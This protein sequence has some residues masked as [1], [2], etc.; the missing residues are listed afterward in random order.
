MRHLKTILTLLILTTGTVFSQEYKLTDFVETKLPKVSSDEWFELNHSRNEFK[1]FI[2]NGAIKIDKA[3]EEKDAILE[4]ETGRLVG[5]DHGEWGGKIEFIPKGTT[6]K[7]LI[8]EGNVK[9]IFRFKSEI[10]FI[11][12]LAH[13]ST[14]KG[15][16]YRLD[17]KVD[18]FVPIKVIEFEDAPEA[19][20]IF[21]D[22]I[23]IAAH[24][25]FFL[26]NDLD[27]KMIFEK[28][29]WSGLYPNSVAAI[30]NQNIYIGHRG[31]FTKLDILNK[32]IR[33][34]KFRTK[35]R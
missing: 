4:I 20:C 23:L 14:S 8:K 29:F 15:T 16:M 11:E 6:D 21:G 2:D 10:Y 17:K 22:N 13:L 1:V 26:V 32:E 9:F 34:F 7:K 25:T 27:K 30:D 28:T 3:D 12:G 18:T 24:R 33:F 35:V 5:S 31:G 19:M